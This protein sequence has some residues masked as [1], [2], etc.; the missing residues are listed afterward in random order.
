VDFTPFDD[1][2]PK[3]KTYRNTKRRINYALNKKSS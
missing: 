1:P 2:P 3:T